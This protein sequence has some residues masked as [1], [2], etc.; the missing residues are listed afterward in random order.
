MSET[1]YRQLVNE[2]KKLIA[3]SKIL[4]RIAVSFYFH[5]R[6]I[7][8]YRLSD[9]STIT[10]NGEE[11]II[12][13]IANKINSFVDV[14]AN[15]GEWT[16]TLYKHSNFTKKGVLYEP[17]PA[18]FIKLNQ[19]L[20]NHEE[21][22]F[23]QVAVGENEGKATLHENP[24]STNLS[25]VVYSK[26]STES[27]EIDMVSLETDLARLDMKE[28]DFLKIDTEG[29]D[30]QVIKG[31]TDL[32]K[33]QAIGLI[34]F[35]YSHDWIPAGSTL[36]AAMNYLESFGYEVLLLKSD[37]VY[38]LN[39]GLYGEY[40]QYSNFLAISPQWQWIKEHLYRGLI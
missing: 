32:L 22:I 26:G 25:S 40:F 35:E 13:L 33:K 12:R 15:I 31:S 17:S 23:R 39:Y 29:Y 20:K 14:G 37:G 8:K 21:L 6:Q 1:P 5:S 27:T 10:Q 2:T 11:L 9:T 19:N 24:K 30:F 4:T 28:V 7:F 16:N 18:V 36:K 38:T 3:K 34:Q